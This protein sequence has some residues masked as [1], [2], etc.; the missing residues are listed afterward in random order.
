M[1]GER[2]SGAL[3]DLLNFKIPEGLEPAGVVYSNFDHEIKDNVVYELQ[4]GDHWGEHTAWNFFGAIWFSSEK[5]HEII[6]RHHVNVDMIIDDSIE[7]VIEQANTRWG[8]G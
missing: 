1:D 8:K 6:M 3:I 7:S 2:M 4:R 5:W